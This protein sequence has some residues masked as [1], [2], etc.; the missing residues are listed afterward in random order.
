MSGGRSYPIT[1]RRRFKKVLRD[2]LEG[3]VANYCKS[4]GFRLT[5]EGI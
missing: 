3:P 2:L 5:D 4:E 1:S